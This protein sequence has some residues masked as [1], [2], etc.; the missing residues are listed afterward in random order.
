MLYGVIMILEKYFD[1]IYC[2]NLDERTD[3]WS[4]ARKEFNK[5]NLTKVKRFSAVKHEKGHLGCKQSH[6]N[7]IK[8]AKDNKNKNV[9]IFEDDVLFVDKNIEYLEEGVK[10]LSNISWDFFYLGATLDP[11]RTKLSRLSKNLLKTN[12]AYTTHAYAINSKLFDYIIGN[13]N[14]RPEIDVFYSK[15]VIPNHNT[16]LLDPIIAIQQKGYSN[17]QNKEIDYNWMI[18]HFEAAK[19]KNKI[20]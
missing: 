5:I 8:E 10:Q 14:K 7:I 4:T 3:R 1:A 19:K 17:I 20:S 12:F 16:V 13:S 2:I 6:I 9:L 11:G 15:D 18:N